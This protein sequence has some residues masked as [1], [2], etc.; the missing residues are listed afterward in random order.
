MVYRFFK[1]VFDIMFSS[2]GLVFFVLVWFVVKLAY[3]FSGDFHRVIYTQKRI[4]KNGKTFKIYKFRS[5]VWDADKELKE[6]L[7]NKKYKKEWDEYQKIG[8]DPRITKIGKI[9]R[10]GSIDEIPQFLNVFLGQMSLIGPRPLVPGE[11]EEHGGDP[12]KYNSVKPGITGYWT[13]RGR[14]DVD[15]EDRLKME[16]YYIDN[17]SFVLDAKIFFR[18]IGAVFR[19]NGAK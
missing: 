16:Y 13:T 17:Q 19:K 3:V 7:K 11:L 10:Q 9:I 14:S 8:D 18:T 15:Y 12:K 2:I 5:M 4:G 1:R 6:L